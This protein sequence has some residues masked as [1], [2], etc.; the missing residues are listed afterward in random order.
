MLVSGGNYSLVYILCLWLLSKRL[1]MKRKM[2]LNVQRKVKFMMLTILFLVLNTS[3]YYGLGLSSSFTYVREASYL[4]PFFI[5]PRIPLSDLI[6]TLKLMFKITILL[7]LIYIFQ[8]FTGV[9]IFQVGGD[10]PSKIGAIHFGMFSLYRYANRPAWLTIFLV[11][12]FI[13]QNSIFNTNMRNKLILV[14][15]MIVDM[16]RT[17]LVGVILSIVYGFSQMGKIK[18]KGVVKAI[19]FLFVVGLFAGE[20]VLSRFGQADNYGNTIASQ[21]GNVASFNVKK[22]SNNI[23]DGTFIYRMGWCIE[24]AY[25]IIDSGDVNKYLFGLGMMNEDYA[26]KIYHF[27]IGNIGETGKTVQLFTYDTDY[28]NLIVRYGLVGSVVVIVFIWSIFKFFYIRKRDNPLCLAIASIFISAPLISFSSTTYTSMSFYTVLFIFMNVVVS[29]RSN[30]HIY[31][32]FRNMKYL[33]RLLILKRLKRLCT[34][35]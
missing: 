22:A 24:R 2:P 16:S 35:I 15:G 25:G 26:Q 32:S 34:K 14:A 8:A 19:I 1:S 9:I 21:I 30:F 13:A 18:S 28:G 6:K 11:F 23:Q 7:T 33:Y 12:V 5:L 17:L 3:I 4:I 20:V 27:R 10:D 29:D 31:L